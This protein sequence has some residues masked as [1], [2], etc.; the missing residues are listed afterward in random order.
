MEPTMASNAAEMT[1][2]SYSLPLHVAAP[3]ASTAPP[4]KSWPPRKAPRPRRFSRRLSREGIAQER[5][6]LV[7]VGEQLAAGPLQAHGVLEVDR[8]IAMVV[9][10]P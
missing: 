1:K 10:L 3:G 7:E 4:N 8:P 9:P 5:A 6:P 2:L